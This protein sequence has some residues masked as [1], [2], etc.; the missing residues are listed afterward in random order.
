[1]TLIL[2]PYTVTVFF[3]AAPS[4][5]FTVFIS[6]WR[7]IPNSSFRLLLLRTLQ[8]TLFF[9]LHTQSCTPLG[10]LG[11]RPCKHF[12]LHRSFLLYCP[13]RNDSVIVSVSAAKTLF[14]VM[15]PSRGMIDYGGRPPPRKKWSCCVFHCSVISSINFCNGRKYNEIQSVY[16]RETAFEWF[17]MISKP[18]RLDLICYIILIS[19]KKLAI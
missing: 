12:E 19:S 16:L 18:E 5:I 6:E 8:Q 9:S 17:I 13:A 14:P 3:L 10:L 2:T 4:I 1:M 15:E 11:R 7:Q